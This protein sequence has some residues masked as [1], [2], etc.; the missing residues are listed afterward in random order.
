MN[1]VHAD[2]ATLDL[3][4]A[5]HIANALWM[6]AYDPKRI[7]ESITEKIYS[8]NNGSVAFG[9]RMRTYLDWLL[10]HP[11]SHNPSCKRCY[12]RLKA[13]C[14][15]LTAHQAYVIASKFL[16]LN[17]SQGFEPM[18]KAADLQFPR[19]HLPQLRTS[20]GWHFFVSSCWD[21]TGSDSYAKRRARSHA[22]FGV[23]ST[24]S[25]IDRSLKPFLRRRKT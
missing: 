13:Y 11:Q 22:V 8:A 19:D 23:S 12:E 25:R 21:E 16:G 18:P 14:F 1:G 9:S 7:A 10:A 5:E 24:F 4:T 20:V 6:G 15:E 3:E 2:T 17:A